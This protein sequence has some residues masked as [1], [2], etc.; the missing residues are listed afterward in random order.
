MERSQCTS[1]ANVL[2][3]KSA[4]LGF[5]DRRVLVPAAQSAT[6]VTRIGRTESA[7]GIRLVNGRGE[8]VSGHFPSFDHFKS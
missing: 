2:D 8:S 3:A 6:P 5:A 4:A 7:P 1:F